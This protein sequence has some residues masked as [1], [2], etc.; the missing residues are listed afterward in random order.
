MKPANQDGWIVWLS[1]TGRKA[2]LVLGK[3][4]FNS[5]DNP[6]FKE[7]LKFTIFCIPSNV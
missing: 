5:F 6:L 7:A 4:S 3:A 1:T 2:G